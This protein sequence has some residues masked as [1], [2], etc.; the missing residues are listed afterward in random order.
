MSLRYSFTLSL[1]LGAF[2]SLQATALV[3]ICESQVNVSLPV[4][5]C[6]VN[7]T[8]D[9]IDGGSYS[10][11]GGPL[12]RYVTGG[13][14]RGP[15]T[16]T[17]FLNIVDQN[18]SS[19]SCWSRVIVEDKTTPVVTCT[20]Q[21][22]YLV[23]PD[24]PH[25]LNFEDM[26]SITDNCTTA[27][28]FSV[29]DMAGFGT[30][31]FSV[32]ATDGSGNTSFCSG[33]VTRVDA[34]PQNYCSSSRN[35]YYEHINRIDL[36][37][38]TNNQAVTTGNSGGY[39]WHY[40]EGQNTLYHGYSYRLTYAPGFR[41]SSYHEYWRVYLDKNGDGDFTDSG[42]LLHQWNGYGGNSFNFTSPGAF[43]GWSR[44]RVVMS[45]GGY[46]GPCGGG[47]GE[48]EDISVYLR[49]WFI[50]IWPWGKETDSDN[51]AQA[52]V[53]PAD[54]LAEERNE[55]P[56]RPGEAAMREGLNTDHVTS[57]T[58]RPAT[59]EDIQIYPNPANSGERIKVRGL[60]DATNQLLL[61]RDLN[62]R[63]IQ[64]YSISG[65]QGDLQLPNNLATGIYLLSGQDWTKRVL[66]K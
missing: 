46:A 36:V 4:D 7:I 29:T 31:P 52:A 55:E 59:I 20:N 30:T 21:T 49:P 5:A 11:T 42:E 65:N 34:E 37:T 57:S 14:N 50:I 17:V 33:T 62:G 27:D 3:A 63:Q 10:T 64:S 53:A 1:F 45:Y 38:A 24:Q 40:P 66:I 22:I 61:L 18:N 44:I 6:T 48:T 60:G 9:M 51:L 56:P 16:Y 28:V 47:Y 13:Y 19:N 35:S 12:T 15:G 39:H 8:P 32:S 2:L 23:A 43:W 25:V 41:S 26:V 54:L 58:I